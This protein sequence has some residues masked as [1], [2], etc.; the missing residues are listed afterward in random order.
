LPST[1]LFE[2]FAAAGEAIA[3]DFEGLNYSKAIR[4]I[5][6][7]ADRA[8]QYIDERKPWLLAKDP[9]NAAE[10]VAVCTLGLN[11]FRSLLIYLK[12]VIPEIAAR[13]ES[14]LGGS[15]LSWKDAQ[16]PLLGVDIE[17]FETLLARV[18]K[19]QVEAMIEET[20]DTMTKTAKDQAPEKTAEEIDIDA[21]SRI[22]LR[23]AKVL[24]AS[25]VDG[26]DKLLRLEVD[27][28]NETRQIFS[29]IRAAYEPAALEGRLVVVVA[30]LKPRKM[31]FGT[32]AGMVLAAGAGKGQIFLLSPD[33]G[34]EPGMKVT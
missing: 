11:L 32:S 10:V 25:Y 3:A 9:A 17:R 1:A 5:M 31:R 13:A 4:R 7:L 28:G 30:N 6:A 23:V 24:S 19:S 14:F 26:A 16:V 21:F 33:S 8:N 20:R 29:G 2:D 34:A 18:D 15:S 12:P 27:L 22:D